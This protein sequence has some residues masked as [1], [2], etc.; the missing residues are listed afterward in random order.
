MLRRSIGTEL[1]KDIGP[2]RLKLIRKDMLAKD[3]GRK[4]INDQ[5]GRIVRLFRWAASDELIPAS[6]SDALKTVEG[7]RKGRTKA[8]ESKP[9]RPVDDPLVEATLPHLPAVVADM[10][11]FQR[12][13]GCRPGKLHL[14]PSSGA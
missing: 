4:Y 1:A 10:V 9:V 11:R 8:T 13:T 3:W 2:K 6:V 12:L 7:L 14:P 5:V